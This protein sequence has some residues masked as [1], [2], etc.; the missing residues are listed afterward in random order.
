MA[1]QRMRLSVLSLCMLARA[2]TC[3]SSSHPS[4]L[5]ALRLVSPAQHDKLD[6][7]AHPMIQAGKAPQACS[8]LAKLVMQ[9]LEMQA[10]QC[11]RLKRPGCPAQVGF[12]MPCKA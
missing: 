2:D 1:V 10:L 8:T 7:I 6:L 9:L 12:G 11:A 5:S 4:R 3:L